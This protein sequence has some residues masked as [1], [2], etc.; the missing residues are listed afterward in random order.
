MKRIK[1]AILS[2]PKS[3]PNYGC[4]NNK[5]VKMSLSPNT[6]CNMRSRILLKEKQRVS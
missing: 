4:V 1:K 5:I 2:E 3:C 6:D